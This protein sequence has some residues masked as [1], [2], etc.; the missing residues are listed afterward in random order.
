MSIVGK[1]KGFASDG[2]LRLVAGDQLYVYTPEPPVAVGEPPKGIVSPEQSTV[3]GPAFSVGGASTTIVI[4]PRPVWQ[5][6]SVISEAS[7]LKDAVE[8]RGP[9]ENEITPPVPEMGNPIA[10][11][12]ESSL[13]W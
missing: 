1:A 2:L 9:V 3:F 7:T 6:G 8:A 10:E 13:N 5:V 4:G 11:L 12:S